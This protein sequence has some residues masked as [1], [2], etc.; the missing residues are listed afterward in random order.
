MQTTD[1]QGRFAVEPVSPE[2]RILLEVRADGFRPACPEPIRPIPGQIS[3]V[4]VTLERGA[5]LGGI[6]R[7]R[8]GHAVAGAEIEAT[9]GDGFEFRASSGPDGTFRIDGLLERP[10]RLFTRKEGFVPAGLDILHPAVEAQISL[11]AATTLNGRVTPARAGLHAIAAFGMTRIA[12][13]TDPDG[14]FRIHGVPRAP[15][16]LSIESPSA[17]TV[18]SRTVDLTLDSGEII[19]PVP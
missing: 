19:V 7:S 10:I 11:S 12:S 5:S 9:Q 2:T 15:V 16:T 6:V 17:D 3:R 1:A 8:E 4:W 18:A 14:R 13:V